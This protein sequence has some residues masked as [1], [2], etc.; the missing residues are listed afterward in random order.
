M[1]PPFLVANLQLLDGDRLDHLDHELGQVGDTD[2]EP[3]VGDGPAHVGGDQIEHLLGQGS[4]LPDAQIW[5]QHHDGQVNTGQQVD[6]IVVAKAELKVAILELLV[7]G[8]QL[9]V[10]RLDLLLRCLQLLVDALELLVGGLHLLVRGLQLL[11]RHLLL[12]DDG[13]KV[14]TGGGQL[15]QQAVCL[16]L[17]RLPFYPRGGVCSAGFPPLRDFWP[18]ATLHGCHVLEKHQEVRAG[19]DTVFPDGDHVNVDVPVAP[20]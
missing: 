20:I 12:L 19:H 8:G 15:L 18:V 6:E 7:D 2:P 10:A 1:P 9:L 4:E 5:A 16:S 11:V 14:F 17:G 3:D 13:L